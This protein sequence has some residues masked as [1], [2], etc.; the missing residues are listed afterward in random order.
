MLLSISRL[1]PLLLI[2]SS[3]AASIPLHALTNQQPPSILDVVNLDASLDHFLDHP[4]LLSFGEDEDPVWMT[5][6][7][8][9]DLIAQGKKFMDM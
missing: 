8:K 3:L 9:F 7:D 1:T 5:E 2:P 6:M 4:R